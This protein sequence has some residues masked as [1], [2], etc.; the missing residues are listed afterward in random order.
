MIVP[1]LHRQPEPVARERHAALRA[2]VPFTDWSHLGTTNALFVVAAECAA[3]ANDHPIVFIPAGKDDKDRPEFAPIAVL[4]L[5]QG[6]NLFLEPGGRWRG[7]QLPALMAYYPFCMAPA[8]GGQMAVCIDAAATT[9][10]EGGERLFD[11]AGEPTPFALRVR[12]DLQK[13]EAQIS[14]TRQVMRRVTDLDLLRPR[15]FDATLEDGSKVTLD[16]FHVVDEERVRALPDATLLELQ[17][18]GILGFVQ[19]HWVSMGQ[20]RRLLKWRGEVAAKG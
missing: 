18:S 11:D 9:T 15:R 7:L 2:A 1:Q 10:G 6:E 5:A 3:I 19:T 13:L 17:R 4:G 16:G 12:E 8:G 14:T 20:M